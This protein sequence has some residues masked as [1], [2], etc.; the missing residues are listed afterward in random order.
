MV[1]ANIIY[2]LSHPITDEIRYV[3]LSGNGMIRPRQ[4]RY[5]SRV[6]EQ[7]PKACWIRSLVRAGLDYKIVVLQECNTREELPSAEVDWIAKLRRQGARLLNCTD[8]GDGSF[9]PSPETRKKMSLAKLG[10]KRQPRSAEWRKKLSAANTGR[11]RSDESV[12][13]SRLARL[14]MKFSDEHKLKL[15]SAIARRRDAGTLV[16]SKEQREKIS[17]AAKKQ[18]ERQ[19]R[20]ILDLSSG[21]IYPSQKE[22]ARTIGVTSVMIG[23]VLK[24]RA[25]S[26]KGHRLTF[27][28]TG[29]L[30]SSAE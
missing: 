20:P 12:E 25:K 21:E 16:I 10:T 26:A 2:G 13:K 23:H 8:G 17:L 29:I 3:G 22:A 11:R 6:A 5:P 28:T 30:D 4:H 14:G 9:N 24:G 27:S 15:R 18:W 7:T 1:A 19:A